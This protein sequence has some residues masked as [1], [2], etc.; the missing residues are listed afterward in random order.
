VQQSAL[1]SQAP[2][3]GTQV[4]PVVTQLPFWHAPLQQ[5]ESAVHCGLSTHTLLTQARPAPQLI[6]EQ[7][8]PLSGRHAPEQAKPV[9]E[10]GLGTHTCEQH[11]SGTVHGVGE[12]GVPASRHCVGCTKQRDT[13]VEVGQQFLTLPCAEQQFCDAPWPPHTSPSARHEVAFWQRLT[14]LDSV[15]HSP[16]QQSPLLTHGSSCTRQPPMAVQKPTPCE[17]G[18]HN[19]SQ[20]ERTPPHGSFCTAQLPPTRQRPVVPSHEWLQQSVSLWQRSP[21]A[22]Q[23]FMNEHLPVDCP[24]AISQKP[25]QQLLLLVHDSPSVV[26]PVPRVTHLPLTQLSLQQSAL[27]EQLPLACTQLPLVAQEPPL[28]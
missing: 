2:P 22:R 20:H 5:S 1:L 18:T 13:P 25:E 8:W 10:P 27:T 4:W 17:F 3:M 12:P 6:V 28:Q 21:S 7:S 23:K 24:Y 26:Q 14:P 16:L 15:A 11:W 19:V 9:G